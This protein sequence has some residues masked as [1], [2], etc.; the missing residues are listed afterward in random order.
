MQI[1][2]KF[3][4]RKRAEQRRWFPATPRK[5]VR[6]GGFE[7][8]GDVYPLLMIER[9]MTGPGVKSDRSQS[10]KDGLKHKRRQGCL[11]SM[12]G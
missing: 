6:N 2:R 9:R 7:N 1:E 12:C 4:V 5:G 10:E 11:Q 8:E 3:Q